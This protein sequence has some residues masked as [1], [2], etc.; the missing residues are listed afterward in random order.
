MRVTLDKAGRIVLPKLVRDEL[1]LSPG[2]TLDLSVE[3]AAAHP[4]SG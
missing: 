3:G 1:R 4:R 2:D